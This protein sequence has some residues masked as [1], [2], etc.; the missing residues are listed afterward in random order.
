MEKLEKGSVKNFVSRFVKS[1]EW[2][3]L[4]ETSFESMELNKK[5]HEQK[6]QRRIYRY[7]RQNMSE[8]K[9]GEV[10]QYYGP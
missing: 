6:N 9:T 2:R 5:I 1:K 3:L 7:R 4:C 8:K 10:F